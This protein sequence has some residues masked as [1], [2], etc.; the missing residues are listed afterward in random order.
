M[1]SE[2]RLEFT[3]YAMLCYALLIYVYLSIYMLTRENA[4]P[5]YLF[6]LHIHGFGLFV[7]DE[8]VLGVPPDSFSIEVEAERDRTARKSDE[9]D[10]GRGPLVS[11]S[12]IHLVGEKYH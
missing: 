11:E 7:F 1:M 12:I 2:K 6:L 3:N 4:L 8:C 5:S 9:R 10:Q